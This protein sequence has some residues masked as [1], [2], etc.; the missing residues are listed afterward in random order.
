MLQR[1]RDIV[2][3]IIRYCDRVEGYLAKL[4]NSRD[5]FY[6]DQ[7]C[8]DAC[9]MCIAQ[10][11]ELTGHLSDEYRKQHAELPWREIKDTRNYYVH[12][13]GGVDLEYV[14]NTA[15]KDLPVLKQHCQKSL[16]EEQE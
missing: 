14:W 12:N 7:M 4:D 10:I 13:Y 16:D 6:E 9:C 8:Q 3:H 15:K 11:G 2:E 5:R 1:D